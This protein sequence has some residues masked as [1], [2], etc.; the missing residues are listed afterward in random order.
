MLRVLD[1]LLCN[2]QT[3]TMPECFC[4]DYA[5]FWVVWEGG[6]F[7]TAEGSKAGLGLFSEKQTGGAGDED[8]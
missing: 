4:R 8:T 3:V 5:D 6:V 1:G 7:V 2:F